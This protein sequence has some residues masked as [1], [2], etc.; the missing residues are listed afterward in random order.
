MNGLDLLIKLDTLPTG[1]I[2]VMI[3]MVCIS[4]GLLFLFIKKQWLFVRENNVS[5]LVHHQKTSEQKSDT[6]NKN[7]HLSYHVWK[8]G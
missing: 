4:S 8:S 6:I 1:F 2:L 7:S 3:T 5:G